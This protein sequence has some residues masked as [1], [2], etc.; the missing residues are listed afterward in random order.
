MFTP[1]TRERADMK[2]PVHLERYL[3]EVDTWR[4]D[5]VRA[6]RRRRRARQALSRASMR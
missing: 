2:L 1:M 3:T 6:Q 5:A 4:R